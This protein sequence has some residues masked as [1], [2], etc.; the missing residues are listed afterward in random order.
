M[1]QGVNRIAIEHIRWRLQSSKHVIERAGAW[2]VFYR[3]MCFYRFMFFYRV[4]TSAPGLSGHY[5]YLWYERFTY[6]DVRPFSLARRTVHWLHCF[7]RPSVRSNH[8]VA[9]K[10]VLEMLHVPLL[11][12]TWIREVQGK[13]CLLKHGEKTVNPAAWRQGKRTVQGK[14][15]SHLTISFAC[16]N[17]KQ[18]KLRGLRRSCWIILDMSISWRIKSFRLR[19]TSGRAWPGP[20]QETSVL[21]SLGCFM[22]LLFSFPACYCWKADHNNATCSLGPFSWVSWHNFSCVA[23]CSCLRFENSQIFDLNTVSLYCI[24]HFCVSFCVF[25]TFFFPPRF[26]TQRHFELFGVN[27]PGEVHAG[28]IGGALHGLGRGRIWPRK[29]TECDDCEEKKRRVKIHFVIKST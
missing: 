12:W 23:S 18:M 14:R 19:T 6:D 5:W 10:S 21:L 22:V 15:A 24:I 20:K 4:E 25:V 11:W 13:L 28:L 1:L 7:W 27:F 17:V 2:F 3:P 26:S 29:R 9:D 16:S 8:R